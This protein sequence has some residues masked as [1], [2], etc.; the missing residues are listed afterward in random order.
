M[1]R[2]PE[3]ERLAQPPPWLRQQDLAGVLRVPSFWFSIAIVGLDVQHVQDGD[4]EAFRVRQCL[5]QRSRS[6]V[7]QAAPD[8]LNQLWW[9]IGRIELIFE[10]APL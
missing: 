4:D 9:W 7:E 1:A 3:P 6:V 10:G 5:G 8:F 2:C